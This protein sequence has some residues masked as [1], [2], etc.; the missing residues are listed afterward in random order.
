[1]KVPSKSE[2]MHFQLQAW[3]RENNCKDLQYIGKR[4]G[5]HWYKILNNEVPV[6]QIESLEEAA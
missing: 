4:N 2:L 3:L 6:S 5:E 1:M